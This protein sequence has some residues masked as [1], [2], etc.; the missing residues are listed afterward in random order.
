MPRIKQLDGLRAVAFLSVF[1]HHAFS[2]SLLWVGV[3]AFFVLSGFLIT[4]I[5]LEMKAD[6]VRFANYSTFC[7]HVCT[8]SPL[9]IISPAQASVPY[10]RDSPG[11][12]A[13]TGHGELCILLSA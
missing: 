5:L 4:G 6:E 3:D 7:H 8:I 11:S 2:V 12:V 1:I 13:E 10:Y 9:E